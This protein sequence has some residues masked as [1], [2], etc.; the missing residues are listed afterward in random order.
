MHEELK[1]SDGLEV[2]IPKFETVSDGYWGLKAYTRFLIVTRAH[3]IPML[4]PNTEYSVWRRFSDFEWF[5][6]SLTEQDEYKGLVLPSLPEK[7]FFSK[8]NEAFVESRRHDLISYLKSLASHKVI[9][10]S[11]L[12]H[13]FLTTTDDDEFN[14]LRSQEGTLKSK[15]YEYAQHLMKI[16][17]DY[18]VAN[19]SQYFDKQE[20]ECFLLPVLIQT[21]IEGMLEY[22]T[23]L[24][25]VVKGIKDKYELTDHISESMS[26]VALSLEKFRLNSETLELDKLFLLGGFIDEDNIEDLDDITFARFNSRENDP[27]IEDFDRISRLPFKKNFFPSLKE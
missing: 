14:E 25:E 7:S 16:D 15:L 27:M 9:K 13:L 20:P 12:F 6:S 21:R 11:R 26:Q 24:A 17:T 5:H 22:E 23:Q 10:N 18:L 2:N 19:I 8:N 1:V 4:E 3:N